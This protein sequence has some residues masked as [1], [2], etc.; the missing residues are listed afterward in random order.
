MQDYLGDF[1]QRLDGRADA[2]GGREREKHA[3][4][5]E[6]VRL[7]EQRGRG[8]TLPHFVCV[9]ARQC[10]FARARVCVTCSIL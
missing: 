5:K 1:R 3:R 2:L 4:H 9:H 6:E 7:I 10:V 8:V